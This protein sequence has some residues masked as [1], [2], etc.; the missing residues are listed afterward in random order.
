MSR[1][2]A[3]TKSESASEQTWSLIS[4]EGGWQSITLGD[5]AQDGEQDQPPQNIENLDS[6]EPQDV[7]NENIAQSIPPHLRH[8]FAA[9]TVA[10]IRRRFCCE[11]M[12]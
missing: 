12:P 2:Q 10:S 7:M 4:T 11:L 3:T 1:E 8:Q 5:D 9:E 6:K